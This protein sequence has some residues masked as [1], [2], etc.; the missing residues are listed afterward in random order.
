MKKQ[1]EKTMRDTKKTERKEVDAGSRTVSLEGWGELVGNLNGGEFTNADEFISKL[2]GGV[3]RIKREFEE[4]FG[5]Q[6]GGLSSLD[7]K[8]VA[9][10]DTDC[11]WGH[12]SLEMEFR[13]K[14][15]ET[16]AEFRKRK[17]TN[18]KKAIAAKKRA[19]GAAARKEA[20]ERKKLKELKEKYE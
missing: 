13:A 6:Y 12:A 18:R 4:Q 3:D 9:D 1:L 20:A 17:A 8:I 15:I 2:Q 14:R 19:A 11:G 5:E 10:V 16:D 7:V